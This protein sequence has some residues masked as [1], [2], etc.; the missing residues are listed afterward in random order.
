MSP[1]EKA[2]RLELEKLN[3]AL[4]RLM[5]LAQE[6]PWANWSAVYDPIGAR[7]DT[8]KALLQKS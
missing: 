7:R 2:L 1:E 5:L 3:D 4:K 6:I 8:L